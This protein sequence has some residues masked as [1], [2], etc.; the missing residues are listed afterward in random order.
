[1]R[2]GVDEPVRLTPIDSYS[3]ILVEVETGN[4][5]ASATSAWASDIS[6]T[7][8]LMSVPLIREGEYVVGVYIAEGNNKAKEIT[9]KDLRNFTA[10]TNR[11]WK[12]DIATLESLGVTRIESAPTFGMIARMLKGERGEFT[13]SSFKSSADM[14]FVVEGV[15]LLPVKG[16]KVAMPGSRHFL[17]APT[18]Q[19]NQIMDALNKGLNKM[20]KD[21]TLRRAYTEAGFFNARVESWQ[22]LNPTAFGATDR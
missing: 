6:Q 16:I 9:G 10:V 15:R 8:A 22:L 4:V 2:A 18:P 21:G 1:M 19:G 12:N 14:D 17:V 5:T 13:L 20:R 11:A 3:R 7:K